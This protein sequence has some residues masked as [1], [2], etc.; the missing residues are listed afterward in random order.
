MSNARDARQLAI[1]A[2]RIAVDDHCEDVVIQDLRGI[3]DVCDYFVICTGTSDRQMRSV[4]DD[5]QDRAKAL[6]HGRFGLSGYEEA[7]WI[8]ADYVDVVVHVFS[9]EARTYY[10]LE[11][12]WGDAKRVE[13]WQTRPEPHD[14][15]HE[16]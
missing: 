9:A 16:T 13:G 12:L 11:L 4:V 14:D 2:A 7:H 5:I 10:D 15:H 3:S 6:G 8:L 1:E